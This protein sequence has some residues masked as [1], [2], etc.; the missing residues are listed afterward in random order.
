MS[1]LQKAFEDGYKQGWVHAQQALAEWIKEFS[2]VDEQNAGFYTNF[3]DM[4]SK[5]EIVQ[6]GENDNANADMP[7]MSQDDG[8][9]NDST[10]V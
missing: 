6:E 8:L 10:G 7:E 1:D 5:L 4:V 9:H 2:N 3:G